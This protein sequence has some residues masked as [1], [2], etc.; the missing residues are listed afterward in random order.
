[1]NIL[2][3][4][5]EKE[6]AVTGVA[7]LERKGY[8][9]FAACGIAEATAI[10]DDPERPVHFVITDHRLA[11]GFGIQFVIDISTSFPRSK[12]AVVSGCLT[13]QDVQK[14]KKHKIPYYHKPLLYVKVIEDLRRLNASN[15][16]EY[17]APQDTAERGTQA[18]AEASTSSAAESQGAQNESAG[19]ESVAPAKRKGFKIWP[20]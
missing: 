19:G 1:M 10:L 7:Q 11:D 17:V 5:D 9:V 16:A 20:F 3:I 12:C 13:E 8:T 4:E 2:F 14:L 6:L 18:V 15:A